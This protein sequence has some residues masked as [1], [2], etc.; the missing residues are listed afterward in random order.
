MIAKIHPSKLRGE[1]SAP[2]S[3]SHTHR[4]L[5]ASAF[6]PGKSLIYNP[7]FCDDTRRTIRA[8]EKLGAGFEIY[9]DR[10]IVGKKAR[11]EGF[12]ILEIPASGST[13]RMLVPPSRGLWKGLKSR[14]L[15]GCWKGL[16]LGFGAACGLK[17]QLSGRKSDSGRQAP[18]GA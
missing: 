2:P 1:V 6:A 15:P 4:A 10:I 14:P 18:R 5:L 9:P 11:A 3:K 12:F 13:L 16:L 17:H 8:L 7:L